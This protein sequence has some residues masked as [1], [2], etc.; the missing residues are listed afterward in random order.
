METEPSESVELSSDAALERV[1]EQGPVTFMVDLDGYEI[2][3]EVRPS[4]IMADARYL[5]KARSLLQDPSLYLLLDRSQA[6]KIWQAIMDNVLVRRNAVMTAAATVLPEGSTLFPDIDQPQ[7]P[8]DEAIASYR[9]ENSGQVDGLRTALASH[10]YFGT[11]KE[12]VAV[13]ILAISDDQYAAW[14]ITDL[15]ADLLAV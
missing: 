2:R 14:Q 9:E 8:S 3:R 1:F 13:A 4:D 7:L 5:D 6:D 11:S 15:L 10:P 12:D